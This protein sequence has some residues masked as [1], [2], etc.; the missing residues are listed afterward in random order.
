MD[1]P[2]PEL[3]TLTPR[4]SEVLTLLAKGLTNAQI[5]VALGLSPLTAKTHVANLLRKLNVASRTEAVGLLATVQ[6]AQTKEPQS[7]APAIAVLPFS[8]EGQTPEEQ[9]DSDGFVD[10][11]ITRLGRRWFP[12]IARC[13]T[14]ALSAAEM[15][16]AR[17]IGEKLGAQFL[18]EGD[19]RHRNGQL[20]VNAR[21]I[22][23]RDGRVIWGQVYQRRVEDLFEIQFAVSA[24]LV[25]ELLR[26]TV[27]IVARDSST[28][29]ASSL[30]SWQWAVRGL[31]QFWQATPRANQEARKCFSEA[32]AE[33]GGSRLAHYGLALTHQR[34]IVEQWG[35]DVPS[36]VRTLA[37]VTQRFLSTHPNEPWAHL[38]ASYVA[39]YTGDHQAAVSQVQSTLEAEPSSL[40]AR[41]LYGQLLAMAGKTEAA[42]HELL[43]ALR[44]SPESPGR[45]SVE[46][47]IALSHFAAEAYDACIEWAKRASCSPRPGVMPYGVL[48]SAHAHR[49]EAEEARQALRRVHEMNSSFSLDQFR[50]M[51]ASTR[52]DI[53]ERYIAG[54]KRAASY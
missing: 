40:R 38:C 27:N 21:L 8:R 7:E 49:G 32:L 6:T 3:T 52:A 37:G 45:S 25:D 41:S 54:L 16:D 35:E 29:P 39:T 34:A 13:S 10:N 50:S 5:G 20:T 51:V 18:V 23:A 28:V 47:A 26:Q 9:Q 33:D 36:S 53:A 17:K 19:Y 46:C 12:V 15:T 1:R 44:V 31:A 24:A 4:E 14:H 22:Q 11:L 48:A 43:L 30:H 2:H 42:V